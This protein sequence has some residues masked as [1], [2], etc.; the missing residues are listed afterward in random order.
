MQSYY[1][2]LPGAYDMTAELIGR[3]MYVSLQ[4]SYGVRGV[5]YTE[6]Y[7]VTA[8]DKVHLYVHVSFTF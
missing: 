2:A 4:G 5:N 6:L 3:R 8:G 1:T 7:K